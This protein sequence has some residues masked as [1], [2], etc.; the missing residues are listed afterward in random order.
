MLEIIKNSLLFSAK[1]KMTYNDNYKEDDALENMDEEDA[2]EGGGL[3]NE[4][5]DSLGFEG[6]EDEY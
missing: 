1:E 5:E 2:E 6:A 3:E 4:E